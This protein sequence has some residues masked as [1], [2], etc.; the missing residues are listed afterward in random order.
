MIGHKFHAVRNEHDGIKFPSKKEGRYYE[1]LKLRQKN[2]EVVFFLMQVP[3]RLPGGVTYRCDFQ[4]F[5]SDGTVEF[6]EVKG[7]ETES[8]K[9]KHKQVED[10][11][12]IKITVI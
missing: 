11:Y 9:I 6:I 1:E 4:V 5:K 3:F 2:G 10:L 12:P 8:W 7:F